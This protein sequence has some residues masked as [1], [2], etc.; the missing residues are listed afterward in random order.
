[1]TEERREVKRFRFYC[2][3]CEKT[4]VSIEDKSERCEQCHKEG[5]VITK[6]W[7]MDSKEEEEFLEREVLRRKTG[8]KK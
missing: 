1:M 6:C 5:G 4:F 8:K 3:D 2:N 7:P